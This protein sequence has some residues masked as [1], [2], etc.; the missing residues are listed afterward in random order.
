MLLVRL[1]R[2]LLQQ[3]SSCH[4]KS[5]TDHLASQRVGPIWH[6]AYIKAAN[7]VNITLMY[8]LA[9]FAC[10]EHILFAV[11]TGRYLLASGMSPVR[12]LQY[13]S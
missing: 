11:S 6:A 2:L 8:A 10:I 12:S 4:I 7:T 1:F 13:I 3:S 9:M 5:T